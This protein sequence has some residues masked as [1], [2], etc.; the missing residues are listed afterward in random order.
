[1]YA[2]NLNQTL[3]NEQIQKWA[4][5]AFAGQAYHKQSDRYAFVPT[6]VV[7]DGMRNAG[8]FPV[9]ASQSRTR[10]EGKEMFTKHMISFRDQNASISKLGDSVMEIVLINSHDGT[11]AYDLSCG[12]F[13]LA[14]LNGL[15]VATSLVDALHIRHTGRILDEV[16][17]GST[18]LLQNAPVI[19]DTVQQWRSIQLTQPEQHLLAESAHSLRFDEEGNA[20]PVEKLLSPRRWEDNGSDL[21]STFNRV[22]E[23]AIKG[24]LRTFDPETRRRNRTREVKGIDQNVRL[25]RA[26][27]SLAEKMAALKAS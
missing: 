17:E 16:V 5:S 24:G 22:Q 11:S 19:N 27:W 25:N 15:M 20:P 10:I 3:T 14:C 2:N 1:M 12:M 23:N 13:R 9:K 7:I 4:P 21:W 26:L 6:S 8:F 18:R